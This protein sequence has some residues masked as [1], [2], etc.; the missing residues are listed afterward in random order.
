MLQ[1][2]VFVIAVQGLGPALMNSCS[3][4]KP[5]SL[6]S[7]HS[8][9]HC[10]SN[11]VLSV[12]SCLHNHWW[13]CTISGLSPKLVRMHLTITGALTEQS[14]IVQ[15]TSTTTGRMQWS[16]SQAGEDTSHNHYIVHWVVM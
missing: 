14:S 11:Q 2:L 5:P 9:E 15:N 12:K 6:A 7:W 1:W 13:N 8:Q 10:Q 16:V 3:L 4:A